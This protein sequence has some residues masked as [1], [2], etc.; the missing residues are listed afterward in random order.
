MRRKIPLLLFWLLMAAIF[1]LLF[2]YSTS[3]LYPT[4]FGNDS[5][6][7]QTIGKY[8]LRGS[9][10]YR[11]LFDHKGPWI[12]F[13]NM[14]GYWICGSKT[15]ICLLQILS[16]WCSLY[17]LYK[18]ART[19]G[20]NELYGVIVTLL[21][22]FFLF[23]NYGEA[24]FTEEYCLPFLCASA[25]WMCRYFEE[26]QEQHSPK[27]AFL[28]GVAFCVCFLTRVTNCVLLAAGVFAI[29]VSLL[30]KKQFIN[31]WKNVAGFLAGVLTIFLPFAIYFASQGALYDMIYGTFLY[32]FVYISETNPWFR[33][34]N[35]DTWF[36]F[37]YIYFCS[38]SVFFTVLLAWLRKKKGLAGWLMLAGVVEMYLYI[39][40]SLYYHYPMVVLPQFI[41]LI[42]ELT[43]DSSQ[44]GIKR[45]KQVTLVLLAM[46]MIYGAYYYKG[47]LSNISKYR[48]P[49]DEGYYEILAQIPEEDLPY[50]M[51]YGS[52][53]IKQIYLE[54][55][56]VPIYPHFA[57]QSWHSRF[58]G[59]T[60]ELV[61]EE[62]ASCRAKWILAEQPYD[63]IADILEEDYS[64]V[65]A[66]KGYELYRLNVKDK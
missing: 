4:Y 64:L 47:W 52:V 18:T 40:S 21:S 25:Y 23:L 32:N 1:V 26:E 51:T 2:S 56:I 29:T 43:R 30:H 41:M 8:W 63:D 11:D 12:F 65:T 13:M 38:Y 37:I 42:N 54:Y 39:N 17:F 27:A 22:M 48:Q 10:P 3:P 28:Y 35:R 62:F 59:R 57:I 36:S 15:G 49:F 60:K 53:R 14:L 45:I 6:Q 19:T 5:A 50:L 46:F 24:N 58:N 34:A 66:E 33:E 61:H 9:V 16:M 55:D 31:F 44:R 20:K 7:F